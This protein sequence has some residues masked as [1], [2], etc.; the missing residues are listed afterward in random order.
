MSLSLGIKY[1]GRPWDNSLKNDHIKSILNMFKANQ[2]GSPLGEY[3]DKVGAE[4]ASLS[5]WVSSESQVSTVEQTLETLRAVT[6][7]EGQIYKDAARSGNGFV[8][9][10]KLKPRQVESVESLLA[11]HGL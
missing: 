8:V 10:Y 1:P 4:D 2:L 5:Y 9:N 7:F 3:L 11:A 6:N